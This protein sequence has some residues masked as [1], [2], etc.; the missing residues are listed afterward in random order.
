MVLTPFT[1]LPTQM[2]VISD[3]LK[4]IPPEGIN[5]VQT[6]I[7]KMYQADFSVVSFIT[8]QSKLPISLSRLVSLMYESKHSI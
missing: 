8:R 7:I 3:Y 4:G 1:F 5:M 2:N 6:S